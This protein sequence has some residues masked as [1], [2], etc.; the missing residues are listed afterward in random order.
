MKPKYRNIIANG[1]KSNG[2]R[3]RVEHRCVTCGK[4]YPHAVLNRCPE[5]GGA[6]DTF[7]NLSRARINDTEN[8]LERYFDL[9][10]VNNPDNLLWGGEG[11]TPCMRAT[12]LEERIGHSC[13]YLKD[14]TRNPTC[15]TKDRIASVGLSYYK[16]LG[17]TE[18]VLSSTG[19]SS[20]AFARG[21]QLF[22]T[23][24]VHIFVGRRWLARLNYPDH[25]NVATYVVEDDFVGAGAA[26]Q[27]F[28]QHAGV[29]FEG[30]FFN[31]AR[32]EGLKLAYL[33]AFDQMHV[34]PEYV[35]QAVSSGMGLLGAYKGAL[36]Y[37]AMGRLASLPKFVAVQQ[38]TC[39]P[40]VDAF[41]ERLD[42]IEKRHIVKNPEGLA[43]AILRGN[44]S[45]AYP[46]IHHLVEDSQGAFEKVTNEEMIAARNLLL[47]CEGIHVCFA[48]ATALAGMIKMLDRGTIPG[49]SPVL[50]NLTGTDRPH[51]P[52]PRSVIPY[53][54]S[55]D[56][57]PMRKAG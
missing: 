23:A 9:L 8:P 37:L 16:E 41:E 28:A 4:Q 3:D 24:K 40:M 38:S 30:G 15:S 14:E 27:R 45:Q 31:P 22:G 1:M 39:S 32:R 33:E 48:A 55:A 17:A 53:V 57:L 46:Y 35:F 10:P 21:A 49:D 36:E 19:N 47:E 42:H 11:N 29:M 25:P 50:V 52:V 43:Y 34:A 54:E 5:D 18:F 6:I 13:I 20:T 2:R 12:G 26:A 56:A 7:Y 44:P 51:N